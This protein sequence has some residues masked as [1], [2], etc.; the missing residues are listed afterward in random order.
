MA[1]FSIF[2][3]TSRHTVQ[4]AK[5]AIT[6]NLKAPNKVDVQKAPKRCG[7]VQYTAPRFLSRHVKIAISI[8]FSRKRKRGAYGHVESTQFS[9]TVII[10]TCIPLLLFCF[11]ALF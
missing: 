11:D 7:C 2:R 10:I 4:S 8:T 3:R 1:A 9:P 5:K 6:L